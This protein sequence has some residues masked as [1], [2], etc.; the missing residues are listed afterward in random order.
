[1]ISQTKQPCERG[2]MQS[3]KATAFCSE[4][5]KPWIL[6]VT[7]LGSSM[8]FLDSS[9]VNVALPAMQQA[10][11]ASVTDMQ[12]VIN[13]YALL[14]GA[15]VL[16]GGSAGDIF[17][18]KKIFNA[19]IVLFA[20]ASVWCGLAANVNQLIIA[21]AVQGIGG[22]MLI[23]SS[24]AII[25]AVFD[26]E[27]R[28][29]AIGTWSAFSALT[30]AIGPVV[31]GWIVAQF[32]WRPI[33]FLNVPLAIV[34]FIISVWKVPENR[35][36]TH[37]GGL[38]LK[39]SLFVTLGLAGICYGMI[40][41]PVL[42]FG[43]LPILVSLIGGAICLVLFIWIEYVER[44]PMMPPRLF[45]SHTFSGANLVTLLLYFALTGVLFFLPYNL[46]MVQGYSA[47]AAGAAFL[48][49]SISLGVLS[50]WSGGLVDKYGAKLPLII[51]PAITAAGFILLGLFGTGNN[52]WTSFFP[53]IMT[54]GLGMAVS[55]A[56]LTT[57]VMNAVHEEE[58]GTASGINNA[59]SR[60]AG[61]LSVGIMGAVAIVIF[62]NQLQELMANANIN[63]EIQA[64]V[65]A[66]ASNM[67]GIEVASEQINE[68]IDRSFLS[69]F[70]FLM[71]LSA[72]FS[73]VCSAVS[74]MMIE[75]KS[76]NPG[77]SRNEEK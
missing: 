13:A 3:G 48:P 7:I 8:A 37:E 60:V 24:L 41:A 70:R 57:T 54:I 19:G 32:S 39:G 5:A 15:L 73:L 1:M 68:F 64:I 44:N 4:E 35:D 72:G 25:S 36:E 14:L 6:A 69:S 63:G 16:T 33:F 47:T 26:D 34:A 17:G 29:K 56:P 53:G 31:G 43:S 59:V 75:E 30:A 62:S 50:R 28:G 66:K 2:E 65:M 55:V 51:G 40:Q 12:W 76:I 74:W 42:G 20:G 61:M 77:Y 10:L 9:V 22:A 46:I 23:P 27:E 67:A 38:D 45:K 49:F 71:Y 18:R 11:F 58:T 21:R 52:Y